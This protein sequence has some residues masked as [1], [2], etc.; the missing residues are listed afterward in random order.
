MALRVPVLEVNN[1]TA[2]EWTRPIGARRFLVRCRPETTLPF[3]LSLQLISIAVGVSR[4]VSH[5]FHEPFRRTAFHFEH[6]G[7]LQRAQ[8]VMHEEERNKNRRTADRHEPFIAE[9][10]WRLKHT[11]S[12]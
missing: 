9:V 2:A 10:A 3:F 12:R 8:P 6:H 11:P 4:F 5:Q 7:A 1:I